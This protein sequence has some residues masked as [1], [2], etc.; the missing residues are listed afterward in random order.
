MVSFDNEDRNKCAPTKF[1]VLVQG[2]KAIMC[3]GMAFIGDIGRVW[4]MPTASVQ[5]QFSLR[6]I[7]NFESF[8]QTNNGKVRESKDT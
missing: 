8:L 2:M 3:Q 1:A 4:G 7:L 5:A 6:F